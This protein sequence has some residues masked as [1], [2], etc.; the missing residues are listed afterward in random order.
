[1]KAKFTSGLTSTRAKIHTSTSIIV[2]DSILRTH[3][4]PAWR[5]RKGL[6]LFPVVVPV[7]WLVMIDPLAAAVVDI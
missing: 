5:V 4:S 7:V 2:I 3:V 1:M 6:V